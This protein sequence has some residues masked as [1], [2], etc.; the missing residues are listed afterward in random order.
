MFL[1]MVR[2]FHDPTAVQLPHAST[3]LPPVALDGAGR[4]AGAPGLGVRTNAASTSAELMGQHVTS[5]LHH[6][7]YAF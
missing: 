4:G 5:W 6:L 2:R 3:C 7:R 1:C